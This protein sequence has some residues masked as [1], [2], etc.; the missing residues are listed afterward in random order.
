MVQAVPRNP[1]GRLRDENRSLFLLAS[2]L[3]CSTECRAADH[4]FDSTVRGI[5]NRYSSHAQ[6]VTL[7]GFASLCARVAT[8]NG[9]KDMQIAE[10]E[11]IPD[12][13]TAELSI[14]LQSSL[15]DRW[16]PF[17]TS[18][19]MKDGDQSVIYVR[20]EGHAMRMLIADY[21]HG[22]LSLVRL[23]L[24]GTAL[25]KWVKNPESNERRFVHNHQATRQT[26]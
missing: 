8:H 9:V 16:Q 15:G 14:F 12:I 2:L 10:F 4:N 23:E 25:S 6:K 1:P 18:R 3:L 22:E 17:V 13:D 20:P 26:D 7:M 21:G 24:D 5:E 19:E 11:D